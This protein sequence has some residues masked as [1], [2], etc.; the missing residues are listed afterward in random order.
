[1]SGSRRFWKI[2][3]RRKSDKL[4]RVHFR[5]GATREDA[6]AEMRDSWV[7]NSNTWEIVSI[8]QISEAQYVTS[9]RRD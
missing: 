7:Y 6:A 8:T 9:T 5:I 4:K 1:M 3:T 2:V